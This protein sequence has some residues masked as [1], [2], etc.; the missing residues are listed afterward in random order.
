M[1]VGD[2]GTGG[3]RLALNFLILFFFGWVYLPMREKE[4]Y[5]MLRGFMTLPSAVFHIFSSVVEEE[6]YRR[7]F[8]V[9]ATEGNGNDAI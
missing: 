1:P 5:R 8:V 2:G 9:L 7:R 3:G 4:R 6:S